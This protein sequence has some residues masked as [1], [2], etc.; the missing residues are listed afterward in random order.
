MTISEGSYENTGEFEASLVY[1]VP[2]QLRLC[3]E[4]LSKKR[5]K[6]GELRVWKL[7]VRHLRAFSES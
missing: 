3:R 2:G 6:W 1:T 5:K 7:G 4:I